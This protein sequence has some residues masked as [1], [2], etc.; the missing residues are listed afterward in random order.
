[1]RFFFILGASLMLA[2]GGDTSTSDAGDATTNDVEAGE[3]CGA[4]SACC[5]ACNDDA[6]KKEI[7]VDGKPVC[8]AG[9]KHP[10]EFVCPCYAVSCSLPPP[11]CVAC[12]GGH[13]AP[14]CDIDANAFTCPV[15]TYP[16]D[17]LDASC[18]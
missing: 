13:I 3:D 14:T 6:L 10:S 1:M 16:Y 15:G 9:L 11:P 5:S 7:C 17:D 4:K 8:P 12:D 18:D 2:C